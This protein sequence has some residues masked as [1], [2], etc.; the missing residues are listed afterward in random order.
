M[1]KRGG[2]FTELL[3]SL[4][5]TPASQAA[6]HAYLQSQDSIGQFLHDIMDE[7]PPLCAPLCCLKGAKGR[8]SRQFIQLF[9][10]SAA[11]SVV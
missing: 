8:E 9:A 7:V 1:A 4:A 10:S 11:S 3:L 5:T 2:A 6:V